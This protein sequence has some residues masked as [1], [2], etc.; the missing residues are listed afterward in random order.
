MKGGESILTSLINNFI[1]LKGRKNQMIKKGISHF[2][3]FI[4]N[5]I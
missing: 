3:E 1:E 5:D 2:S 4:L